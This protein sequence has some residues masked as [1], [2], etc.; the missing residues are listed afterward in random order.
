MSAIVLINVHPALGR[1]PIPMVCLVFMVFN[2][3]SSTWSHWVY[4]IYSTKGSSWCF[5]SWIMHLLLVILLGINLYVCKPLF[6]PASF[7]S[8]S[9]LLNVNEESNY[10]HSIPEKGNQ[11]L[12][13]YMKSVVANE[14]A[15]TQ[16]LILVFEEVLQCISW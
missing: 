14:L 8:S 5:H 10:L 16:N 2:A 7:S 15:R 6:P 3:F 1:D 4:M 12:L 11:K 9:P 13:K